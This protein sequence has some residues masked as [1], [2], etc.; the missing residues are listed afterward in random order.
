MSKLQLTLTT[1]GRF[2]SNHHLR[3]F[4]RNQCPHV[5][6]RITEWKTLFRSCHLQRE[7]QGRPGDEQ[8]KQQ[9]I[10]HTE[11][12][13]KP[14]QSHCKLSTQPAPRLPHWGKKLSHLYCVCCFS[15]RRY[16]FASSTL[17]NRL[18]LL[19]QGSKSNHFKCLVLQQL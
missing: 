13:G 17:I 7:L 8:D 11:D 5:G 16:F 9:P 10:A 18:D 3:A 19:Q 12:R 2:S 15:T 4:V 1:W 6:V 14:V